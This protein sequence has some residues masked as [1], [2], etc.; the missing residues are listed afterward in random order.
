MGNLGRDLPLPAA[1]GGRGVVVV[2][3]SGVDSVLDQQEEYMSYL[4]DKEIAI[5]SVLDHAH[6]VHLNEVYD[7]D[8]TVCFVIEL[9]KGGKI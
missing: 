3:D 4:I 8:D 7:E 2:G 1:G 5:M 6:I 9:A